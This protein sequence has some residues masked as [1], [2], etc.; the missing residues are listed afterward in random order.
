MGSPLLACTM[1]LVG[2]THR[3][4]STHRLEDV[5]KLPVTTSKT[6]QNLSP[7][8][9]TSTLDESLSV[10]PLSVSS[11]REIGASSNYG[12]T[13]GM[14]K[15]S[16]CWICSPQEITYMVCS[17]KSS[18]RNPSSSQGGTQKLTSSIISLPGSFLKPRPT[19]WGLSLGE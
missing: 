6:F 2:S 7:C 11:S 13:P 16:D 3:S 8:S 17:T 5:S 14:P 1:K 15:P 10:T 18:S 9:P 4:N 19:L 12:S